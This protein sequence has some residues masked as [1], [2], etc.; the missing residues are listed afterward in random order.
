MFA[1]RQGTNSPSRQIQAV[2]VSV[3]MRFLAREST[4]LNVDDR[5][6]RRCDQQH[7]A[8]DLDPAPGSLPLHLPGACVHD[9]PKESVAETIDAQ[10]ERQQ[11]MLEADVAIRRI[12]ARHA[13]MVAADV[14]A[15][16]LV[17]L[18]AHDVFGG[19][20][21]GAEIHLITLALESREILVGVWHDGLEIPWLQSS[22]DGLR[23]RA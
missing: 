1:S 12:G 17:D 14:R 11:Q 5:Q 21:S 18:A 7:Q 6:R 22:N 10:P 3:Y 23:N 9:E 13:L 20:E 8:A 16:G 15:D 19:L 2:S 4:P